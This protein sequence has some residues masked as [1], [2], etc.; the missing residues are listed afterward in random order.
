MSTHQALIDVLECLV[1]LVPTEDTCV[2]TRQRTIDLPL[3]K[4][5][6][7][8]YDEIFLFDQRVHKVFSLKS[9]FH[10]QDWIIT[11]RL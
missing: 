7:F 8:V 5:R 1:D 6:I 3:L 11:N 10:L 2:D 9:I 4:I